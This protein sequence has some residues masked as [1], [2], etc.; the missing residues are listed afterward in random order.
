MKPTVIVVTK[1]TSYSKYIENTD[2]IFQEV[3]DMVRRG[4]PAVARWKA[5]HESHSKTLDI[6]RSEVAKQANLLV[7]DALSFI[8]DMKDVALVVTV[9]GDGTLLAAS[10]SVHSQIPILGVNSDPNTSVGF[11]CTSTAETFPKQ[12]REALTCTATWT[13]L[14]RMKVLK[15]RQLID[16]RVLNDVLFCHT[17]PASTSNYILRLTQRPVRE[18]ETEV[19]QETQKSSGF[20]VGPPAG[21]TAARRSAGFKPLPLQEKSLQLGVRELYYKPGSSPGR[22]ELIAEPGHTLHA[23]SKMDSAAM[24]IDGDYKVVPVSLGDELIFE[25]SEDPLCLIGKPNVLC[26]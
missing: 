22:Q 8:A 12:L 21:S 26:R 15:N 23:I 17:C 3:R 18:E 14:T 1:Q 5:S 9:G 16:S 4:D 19:F 11:F 20:W 10:H 7:L 13:S 6:V 2:N 24:Y 25:I